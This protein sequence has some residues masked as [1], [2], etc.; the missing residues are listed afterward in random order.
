MKTYPVSFLLLAHIRKSSDNKGAASSGA[1][2]P[3]EAIYGSGALTKSA[4]WVAMLSR[5][6]YNTD[7]VVRNTT[8]VVLS[9]NRRGS[10]TGSAGDLYYC[11]DTHQMYDLEEWQK[12]NGIVTF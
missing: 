3:E 5:D 12:E 9:K 1:F 7:P 8:H 6:K 11:S 10:I 4:S 2:V